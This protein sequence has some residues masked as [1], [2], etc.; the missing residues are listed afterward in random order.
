MGGHRGVRED[1]IRYYARQ[2]QEHGHHITPGHLVIAADVY[3][4]DSKAQAVNEG[5]RPARRR[6]LR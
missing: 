6:R 5:D 4:A 1:V 3:V 2:L